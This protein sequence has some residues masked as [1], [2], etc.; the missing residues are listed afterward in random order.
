MQITPVEYMFYGMIAFMILAF[1]TNIH[2]AFNDPNV[3]VGINGFVV[4]RCISGYEFVIGENGKPTQI[5][6]EL[7]KGVT[8]N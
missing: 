2:I 8:C 6:N 1:I 5:L 7:G 3:S 4:H